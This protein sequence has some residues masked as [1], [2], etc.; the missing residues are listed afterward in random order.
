MEKLKQRLHNVRIQEHAIITDQLERNGIDIIRGNGRFLDQNTIAV[1]QLNEKSDI[2]IEGDRILIATG[3][4]PRNP[5]YVPF[6]HNIFNYPTYSEALKIAGLSAL[7][8]IQNN[9]P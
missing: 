1:R 8:K 3:S 6:D 2:R 9:H 5:P 4:Q 7:N